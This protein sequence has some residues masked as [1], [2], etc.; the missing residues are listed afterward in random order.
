MLPSSESGCP[1]ATWQLKIEDQL[2]GELE[3]W[4]TNRGWSWAWQHKPW[5]LIPLLGVPS[6]LDLPEKQP[7]VFGDKT[8]ALEHLMKCCGIAFG[9]HCYLA[10]MN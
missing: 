3:L 1:A 6:N 2:A 7:W 10:A 8:D 9:S 4:P 5:H